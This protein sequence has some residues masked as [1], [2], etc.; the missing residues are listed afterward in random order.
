M[1][2]KYNYYPN[3]DYNRMNY[4]EFL[5]SLGLNNVNIDAKF[6]MK[7]YNNFSE[8]N[9][10]NELFGPYEGYVKGNMFR[11]TYKGYKNYEPARLTPKSEEDEALLNLNQM[12]FAMHEANLYLDVYPNDSNMMRQFIKF[13]DSYNKLL[14]EYQNRYGSLNINSKYLKDTPFAWEEE[15]F[16]WDRRGL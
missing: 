8:N 15:N 3:N 12:H 10:N 9:N 14:D 2:N 4:D 6:N 7:N 1:N 5:N 13:R 16:P 11:K